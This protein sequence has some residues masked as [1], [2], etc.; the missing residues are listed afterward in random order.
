MTLNPG[1]L[2]KICAEYNSYSSNS[3]TAIL[4][5]TVYYESNMTMVLPSL[6]QVTV[7]PQ[8]LIAPAIGGQSPVAVAYALFTISVSSS[9]HGFYML[10]LPGICPFMPL[11]VGYNQI[12]YSDFAYGWHHSN[13]CSSVGFFGS[14]VSVNNVGVAYSYV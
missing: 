5:G 13:Q 1:T 8:P 10:S 7:E 9:A 3:V 11:A 2:G 14:Y 12:N 4:N 6:I